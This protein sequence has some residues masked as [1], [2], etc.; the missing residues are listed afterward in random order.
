[1]VIVVDSI[2]FQLPIAQ[3]PISDCEWCGGWNGVGQRGRGGHGRRRGGTVRGVEEARLAI[4]SGA[5]G[6]ALDLEAELLGDLHRGRSGNGRWQSR[7]AVGL[8]DA[9]CQGCAVPFK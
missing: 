8:F 6:A 9:G 3:L 7:R 4:E 1:L 2:S 5:R